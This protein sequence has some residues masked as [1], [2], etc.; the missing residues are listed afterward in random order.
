MKGLVVLILSIFSLSLHAQVDSL[1]LS[2]E[3]QLSAYLD[4]LRNSK[5]DLEKETA[6]QTFKNYLQETIL[7]KGAIDYPFSMLR[8]V[9]TIKSPD[10]QFRFFN[11]N[12]E[13]ADETHKYYCFILKFD[14]KKKEWKTIELIDNS[15]MLAPQPEDVLDETTWYGALYY[16]IIPVEKSNKTYYTLLGYDANNNMSHTK[17][18]DVLSFSGNHIKLGSPIFKIKD[19][20]LKRV[21]FEHSKKCVMSLNYDEARNRI[22]FDHLSPESQSMEGFREFYVPDFSYDALK[23]SNNKWV[24]EEDVIGINSKSTVRNK[25]VV[26]LDIDKE[27]QL[28]RHKENGKWIDPSNPNVPAGENIHTPAFPEGEIVEPT[29]R[30]KA[31][32][33]ESEFPPVRK[34]GKKHKSG[35][36]GN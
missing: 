3:K 34:R 12:V 5:S 6:N 18:I 2:R 26:R 21:F 29:E 16:K 28:V 31:K 13:Q 23:L 24:L 8:S 19:Q 9:G 33:E 14:E 17:L 27:G 20:V 10:N 30:K 35:I 7:I 4:N 25:S 15:M 32:K 36:T 11:W 22:I 1:F